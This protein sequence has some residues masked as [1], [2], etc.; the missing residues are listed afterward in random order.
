MTRTEI[1]TTLRDRCAALPGIKSCQLGIETPMVPDVYPIVRIVV[2]V[3]RHDDSIKPWDTVM[4][5]LVY[6]GEMVRPL[7]TGEINDQ[8]TWLMEMEDR[9]RQAIAPGQGYR[10]RWIET[11]WDEDRVPGLRLFCSRFHVWG[12]DKPGR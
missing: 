2:S 6:Y 4:E 5:L 9:I 10:A 12:S 1:L 7:K 3:E 11:V 8:L